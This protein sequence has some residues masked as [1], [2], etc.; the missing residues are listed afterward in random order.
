MACR[1][2]WQD[3]YAV[4]QSTSALGIVVT[5]APGFSRSTNIG[6]QGTGGGNTG[7]FTLLLTEH[8]D[9]KAPTSTVENE[10]TTGKPIRNVI[11]YNPVIAQ[12]ASVTLNMLANAYNSSYFLNLLFQGG[13]TESVGTGNTTLN[14]LTCVPYTTSDVSVWGVIAKAMSDNTDAIDQVLKGAVCR[15]ITLSGEEGGVVSLSAEMV[16]AKWNQ[17]DISTKLTTLK[18]YFDDTA[19][20]RWQDATVK[21]NSQTVGAKSFNVTIASEPLV[22]YYNND[23]AT[24]VCLGRLTATGSITTPW[25]DASSEGKNKQITDFI[26]GVDKTIEVYWGNTSNGDCT[27]PKGGGSDT[28]NY[29]SIQMNARVTDYTVAGDAE[30][31]IE[32]QFTATQDSSDTYQTIRIYAGYNKF[33]L[34]RK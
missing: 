28:K 17:E 33:L 29:L 13:A 20:L 8:P 34:K 21:I 27:T 23:A 11:E 26:S 25:G 22:A 12:P 30:I 2:I 4:E 10:L 19:P 1:M 3:L 24:N 32:S 18:T 9:F 15:Q 5:A 6:I 7:V 16:A 31:T 14:V